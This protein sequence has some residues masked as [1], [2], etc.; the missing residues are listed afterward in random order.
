MKDKIDAFLSS[1][2]ERWVAGV[3]RRPALVCWTSVV[4][5]IALGTYA[6]LGLGINSDNVRMLA[7]SL[8]SKIA[9]KQFSRFFPNL[10]DALLVVIDGETTEEARDATDALE[11]ALSQKTDSF[12]DVYVPGGGSFFERNGLLYRSVDEL[13]VF[14]DQ[15]AR[16]QPVLAQLD[17]SPTIE[18]LSSIIR[19]GL[20]QTRKEGGSAAEWSAILDQVGHATVTVFD[21]FPVAVSWEEV[22]LRGSAIEVAKRRVLVAHPILDFQSVLAAG[23]PLKV[24]R[25]TAASL[26]LTPEHGIRVR[27]TGNPA[28]NYEEMIGLAWDI[29]G[30]SV[31]CFLMVCAVLQR[32]LRSF[33]LMLASV[34]TLLMGLVLTAAFATA[35]VHQL[36][37]LSLSFAVLFIGLG[38]DFAIHLGAHYIHLLRTG[39]P[40]EHALRGAASQVGSSLVI[41]TVTTA[42]GFYVFLPSQY[43]G[44]AE[45]GLIAGTGMFIILALTLTTLPA[46]LCSWLALDPSRPPPADVHFDAPWLHRMSQHARLIRWIS[47]AVGVVGAVLIYTP[48]TRF[49]A[50]V[51]RMR[52]PETESV[53]AFE[54]LMN[55]TATASPW[56]AN[57]VAPNLEEAE[58]IAAR[59]NQLPVV[60]RAITLA[61]YVPSDQDEKLE[62]L[63]D[64]AYL[65]AAPPGEGPESPLEH[66]SVDEQVESLRELTTFL[67]QDWVE[68]SHSA[69]GDS[70]RLL[71]Q[72][73][74]EFLARIETEKDPAAALASLQEVLL[75]RL[76]QQIQRLRDAVH[77]K[78]ITLKTLPAELVRR[79]LAPGG[80]AR[81]QIFP[82]DDLQD[83]DAMAAFVTAIRT[84]DPMVSGISVNLYDFSRATVSS[85]QYA[86]TAGIVLISLMLFALW[87][88][89]R[90]VALV[91]APLLLGGVVTVATMAVLGLRFNFANV[92][93]LP[94]LLGIGV[95]SGIHLVHRAKMRLSSEDLLLGTTTARAVFYS[96]LTTVVSFGTLAFSSHR[97]VASLGILLTA[98]MTYVVLCNLITL[99]AL[100][101]L[102]QRDPEAEDEDAVALAER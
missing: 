53:Q 56:Y 81:V 39:V 94:L 89:L 46:L 35:A 82:R 78:R 96:A 72:R 18:S 85:F 7:D 55:M 70:M 21:E 47:L 42:I 86:L 71:R 34:A 77:A 73:L 102:R 12:T 52:N 40:H 9:Y 37:I 19:M 97:G 24:I 54:D 87:R 88:S 69:L 48:G 67:S 29:G 59:M 10:D 101:E 23:R 16:L 15:M 27:I 31:F 74:Q 92:I 98:G 51:I 61:D 91:L 30:S 49:D 41:C 25:D 38:I 6:A 83:N 62:I 60:K 99:P 43:R 79:M 1:R 22:L 2:I 80:Q 93:V 36:N 84:V 20:D 8:P 100:I 50:N 4:L 28:L 65:L 63:D 58:R 66:P 13:D 57:S 76:P 14:A 11:K 90:D 32:A 45:L 33:R 68:K 5:T 95:D 44:V 3:E 26:G 17:R 75:A 64:T